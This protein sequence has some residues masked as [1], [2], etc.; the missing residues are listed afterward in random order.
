MFVYAMKTLSRKPLTRALLGVTAM[1]AL[2]TG[3][4][5]PAASAAGEFPDGT[6]FRMQNYQ[7][8][9]CAATWTESLYVWALSRPVEDVCAMGEAIWVQGSGNSI[10]HL[11]KESTIDGPQ[12]FC[13]GAD[14]GGKVNVTACSGA[15]DQKWTRYSE[16]FVKNWAT[17][18]CLDVES[19]LPERLYTRECVKNEQQKWA[20]KPA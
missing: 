8:K 20:F 15:N 14:G 1:T 11:I 13:L 7:T 2:L 9:G 10:R 3:I 19:R 17:K 16:G 12:H 4:P 6:L 18:Q 5:A